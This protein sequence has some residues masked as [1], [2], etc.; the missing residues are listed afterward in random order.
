M[1]VGPKCCPVCEI[2]LLFFSSWSVVCAFLPYMY[3]AAV[4]G[5]CMDGASK[6]NFWLVYLVSGLSIL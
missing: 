4:S 5:S 2:K 1:S 6:P 3:C